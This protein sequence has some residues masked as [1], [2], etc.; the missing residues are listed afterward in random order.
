MLRRLGYRLTES[1][2]LGAAS[3]ATRAANLAFPCKP[4][5]YLQGLGAVFAGKGSV[6]RSLRSSW[7]EP[8]QQR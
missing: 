6:W 7:Q 2:Y 1:A 8:L 5:G 3:R 4:D